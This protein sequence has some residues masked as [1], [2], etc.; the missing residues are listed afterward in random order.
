ML[1]GGHGDDELYAGSIIGS[2]KKGGNNT[3]AQHWLFGDKGNDILFG[4]DETVLQ[5]MWGGEGHD[6]LFGGADTDEQFLHGNDGADILHPNGAA[7]TKVT[8]KG[9]AGNDTINKVIRN[10]DGTYSLATYFEPDHTEADPM[11]TTVGADGNKMELF[12][13][14]EGDDWIWGGWNVGTGADALVIK[15]GSGN[16]TLYGGKNVRG[17]TKIFGNGG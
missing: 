6:E 9:G 13:G 4:E 5:K 16:D 17:R 14:N 2:T 10:E 12:E 7:T 1:R 11:I 15:G 8:A 3:A